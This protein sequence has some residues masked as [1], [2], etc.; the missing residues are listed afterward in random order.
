MVRKFCLVLIAILNLSCSDKIGSDERFILN[1]NRE[2]A[3]SELTTALENTRTIPESKINYSAK[4]ILDAKSAVN[5][6]E[7]ILFQ[8]YGKDHIKKQR[9]YNLVFQNDYWILNGTRPE[10]I[11]GGVFLIIMN[12]KNGKIVELIHGK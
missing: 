12:S 4:P 1:Q 11:I 5:I 10:P 7:K 6:A 3:I 9:P 8:V 2:Y